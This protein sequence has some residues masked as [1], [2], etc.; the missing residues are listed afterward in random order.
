VERLTRRARCLAILLLSIAA[1]PI[2]FATARDA[3]D[4]SI[5]QFLEQDDS[6]PAYRAER[7]LEAETGGRRGWMQA[8]TSYAPGVGFRYEITGEGGSTFIRSKVLR[9]VLD[10]ER[11]VIEQGET[12]RSSLAPSNY[13]FTSNG[14]DADGLATVLLTPRRKERVL[15]AGAMFLRP[16]DGG[17]VRLQGRLAKSPSF[18][19]KHVDIVR[20]YDRIGGTIVPIALDSRAQLRPLGAATLRMTYSYLEINGRSIR[21]SN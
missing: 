2:V 18:W 17:L 13:T 11:E 16:L 20:H 14:V 1:T 12:A 4:E 15:I 5:R 10:G 9:A 19:L 3:A 21:Q 7:R 8:V 6:Q